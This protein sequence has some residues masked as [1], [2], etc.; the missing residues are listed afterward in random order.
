MVKKMKIRELHPWD[1]GI[2]Q[3]FEVQQRLAQQVSSEDAMKGEPHLIAGLDLSPPDARGV[4]KG[5]AV[6]LNYPE[7]TIQEVSVAERE[8]TFPYVPGLLAFREAPALV[9]ALEGLSITPDLI[10]VDGQGRAHPRR[11]GIACHIGLLC[12]VPTLGCAKSILR[13]RHDALG[14]GASASAPLVD[15]GEIVGAAVRTK[16]DTSPIYVSIGHR[17]G[18]ESSVKWTLKACKGYRLP[19]P[20]R[21]AHLAAAGT[22][23]LPERKKSIPENRPLPGRLP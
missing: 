2:Q 15:Q 13:G 21:L 17:I 12:Q 6:V 20:T 1:L 7:L 10:F 23:K 22:L 3:A 9:A 4:A 18:L 11:F 19:E 5:A 16:A 8:V 14:G